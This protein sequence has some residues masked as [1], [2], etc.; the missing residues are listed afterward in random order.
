MTFF[1]ITIFRHIDF[2][3]AEALLLN[4]NLMTVEDID[5]LL[6]GT[7]GQLE[8]ADGVPLAVFEAVVCAYEADGRRLVRAADDSVGLEGHDL[9]GG[10]HNLAV[11]LDGIPYLLSCIASDAEVERRQGLSGRTAEHAGFAN[12]FAIGEG[13]E[14]VAFFHLEAFHYGADTHRRTRL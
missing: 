7:L 13:D 11:A 9:V 10:S 5:A 2:G 14:D 8:T 3:A 4:H 6:R 1:D 12:D